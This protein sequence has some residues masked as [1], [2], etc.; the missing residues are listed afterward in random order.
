ML[1]PDKINIRNKRATFDYELIET[2]NAGIVLTGSEIKSIRNGGG[3]INEAYCLVRDGEVFLK[4]MN[5]PEYTLGGYANHDAVRLRKL[6]LKKREVEK[7]ESKIKERGY[8]LV[9]VRL[10]ISERGYAKVEIALARGKKTFDKRETLKRKDS[11]RE[12]ERVMK[13]YR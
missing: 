9:P 6:L 12:M 8:A 13:K 5:I 2:F 4:N 10:Y 11:K 3:S 1:S 7:I